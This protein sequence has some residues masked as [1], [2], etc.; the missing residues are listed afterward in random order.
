M[1]VLHYLF[2]SI[3]GLYTFVV[4]VTVVMSWLV[5]F[6]IINKHNQLVGM[7]WNTCLALTEP[8]LRPIRNMLPNLGGVDISPIV[9]LLGLRALQI[10]VNA[11]LFAPLMGR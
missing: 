5:G 9:L 3:I 4:L 2:N 10:G 7:I 8:A 1:L 11:Y 6:N